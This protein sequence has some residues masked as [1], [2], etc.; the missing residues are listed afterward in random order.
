[1]G[2]PGDKTNGLYGMDVLLPGSPKTNRGMDAG[3]GETA[4]GW[5][6][7]LSRRLTLE[8]SELYSIASI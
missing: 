3:V 1:M 5:S 8:T 6:W 7:T 2:N 4:H